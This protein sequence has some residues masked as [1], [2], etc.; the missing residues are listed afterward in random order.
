MCDAFRKG[1]YL[2]VIHFLGEKKNCDSL[3]LYKCE[4]LEELVI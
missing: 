3:K 1:N 2:I 4:L